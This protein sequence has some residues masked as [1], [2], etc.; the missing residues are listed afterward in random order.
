MNELDLIR[1]QLRAERNR[2]IEVA[3][4]CAAAGATDGFRQS[5]L[6]YL[7]FVL[8]RFEERDQM[9]AEQYRARLPP[10]DPIRREVDE[11]MS[12]P[13]T[14]REALAKLEA[15][16]GGPTDGARAER[17]RAFALFFEGS[18]RARRDAI[19]GLQESNLRVADWR[20][21]SFVDADS[22]LEERTRYARVQ[23]SLTNAARSA[24][25]DSTSPSRA[26]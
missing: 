20:A 11:I 15:A 19:D 25:S 16:L 24:L 13:G 17:W 7:V 22:I 26:S 4:A 23:S 3:L 18:W 21:V 14:S 8:T 12:R 6:D 2:V 1:G 10:S 9:L 5:A